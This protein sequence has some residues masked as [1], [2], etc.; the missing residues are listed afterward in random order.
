MMYVK[1]IIF[2]LTRLNRDVDLKNGTTHKKKGINY[3][4]SDC[5]RLIK[6][7]NILCEVITRFYD[8]LNGVPDC[9]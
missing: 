7:S 6:L 9:P 1:F 5:F 3:D 2:Y 8:L 4:N